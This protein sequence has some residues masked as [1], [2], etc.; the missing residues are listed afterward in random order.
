MQFR[1]DINGL[2]A[3]AVIAVVLFHFN[4]AWL[5]GGFA[6]VD[7]FFVIS[8]FLMTGI[9]FRGIEK[10]N[11]LLFKFYVS[12]ANR[13]IPAL[14]VLCLALLIF[15]WFYL[16]SIDYKAMS[17][18]AASSLG[19]VSNIVYWK[20][21]GY[22][23]TSSHEKWLL[24]T[25]SLSVEWQ[26]YIIYP[27]LLVV[28][29]KFMSINSMKATVIVGTILG[30]IFCIVATYKWPNSAYYLLPTRSWEMMLGGVAYLYPLTLQ[31]QKKKLLEWL[32]VLLIVASYFFISKDSPWPGYLA[33]FPV[34][35]AFFILQ[36]QRND[37]VIT[38][39]FICQKIG[40]WS[41]SIYLWHWPFV[42]T[43]FYYSLNDIFIYLGLIFTI[44]LG[45]LSNKYI[46]KIKFRNDFCGLL[47]YLKC[48]PIY[49]VMG[50]V[51]LSYF[52]IKTGGADVEYR[53]MTSDPKSLY[54]KKYT[55][56]EFKDSLHI[57]LKDECNFN[58]SYT[59][60]FNKVRSE[61]ASSCFYVDKNKKTVL[62]WGDSHAQAI[63][64]GF[65]S[66]D[67]NLIQVATSSC[68]PD[69]NQQLNEKLKGSKILACIKSNDYAVG[70]IKKLSPDIVVL[71]Q[72]DSH[73]LTDFNSI[74]DTI[75]EYGVKK[76]VVIGPVIQ[77]NHD[78]ILPK[79]I[80]RA[81]FDVNK[82]HINK[83]FLNKGVV[84]SDSAMKDNLS[85]K[86]LYLSLFDFLCKDDQCLVKVDNDNT[87]LLFDY[88]H[89]TYEGANYIYK[90]Y[91]VDIIENM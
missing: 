74:S 42:V 89:L 90:Y 66:T 28:M 70:L 33:L 11:F 10:R 31:A 19:F 25:W 68:K 84:F 71:A 82:K 60:A 3:I 9:I 38:N 22:F 54:L 45:F 48:K 81:L 51:L 57:T 1:T 88:G 62:I 72:R 46:E 87:P 17:N 37:S 69:I 53:S 40:T 59:G 76:V 4:A 39:N 78:Y 58:D 50:G 52:I 79:L 6:G 56:K 15:G 55:S 91:L 7:V 61:L 26:F 73:E 65:K 64:Q 21:S 43:I 75:K 27:L 67:Y 14:A 63:A 13:I 77:L 47:S 83:S 36:A 41:Y 20:E 12:R 30:F 80:S 35:G 86:Y 2:R 23:S 34:L 49:M 85:D 32:G 8:G 18:H 5:P 24:H 29:R 44:L 16:N